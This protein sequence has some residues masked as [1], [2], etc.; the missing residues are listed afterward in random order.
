MGFSDPRSDLTSRYVFRL[1]ASFGRV[2]QVPRLFFRH[3]PSPFTPESQTTAYSR[4]FV[5]CAG[6][7]IS[8]Q[9]DR[10]HWLNEV[11]SGSLIATACVFV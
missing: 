9:A 8:G 3:T 5:V 1:A 11:V 2:S 10:S 6:F 4:F 7:T